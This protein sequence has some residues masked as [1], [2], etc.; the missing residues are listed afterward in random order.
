[1]YVDPEVMR[2]ALALVLFA[3]TAAADP[4]AD[5]PPAIPQMTVG[6]SLYMHEFPTTGFHL[7]G[8]HHL[9]NS[10]YAD[11]QASIGGHGAETTRR[12]RARRLDPHNSA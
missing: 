2:I 7:A 10:I 3:S 6:L 12:S 5:V 1:M 8:A 4:V 11:M 9:G